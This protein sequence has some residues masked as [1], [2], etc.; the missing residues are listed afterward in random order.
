MNAATVK[1][2]ALAFS[3]LSF[4]ILMVG[5]LL[6]GARILSS[7]I[8]GI[9]A[10]LLFGLLAWGLGSM[11]VDKPEPIIVMQDEEE[12]DKGTELDKTV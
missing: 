8:R 11:L 7:F 9:E 1:K 10:G 12:K 4:T 6:N 2:L 5:S 3:L